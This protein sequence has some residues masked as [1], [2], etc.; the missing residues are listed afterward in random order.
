M[1]FVDG[2]LV[3]RNVGTFLH[4]PLQTI[5]AAYLSQFRKTHGISILTATRLFMSTTG[6]HRIPGIMVLERPHGRSRVVTD[7]PAAVIEIKSPRDTFDEVLDKC[8]EFA[9]S[10]SRT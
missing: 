3:G 4:G 2:V 10:E 9:D 7:V 6:H 5:V 1:E 8:L